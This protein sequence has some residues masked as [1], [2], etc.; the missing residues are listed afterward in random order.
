M[1]TRIDN[2]Q[3]VQAFLAR[4]TDYEKQLG[5]RTRD[6]FDL[7]RMAEMLNLLL[8]P[9]T[10]YES[11]H[12]AGTKGKGS[13]SAYLAAC[14]QSQGLVTGLFTSPHLE[15]LTQRIE[16]AGNEITEREMV[17]A[18]REVVAAVES[19]AGGAPDITFFELLT[20]TAMVA[21]RRAGVQIAV[22]EVGLGGRLDSTNVITPLVSVITEIGLDHMQQLGDTIR[23]IAAEKA[24]IIKPGIP[25]VCGAQD[26]E[27]QRVIRQTARDL[28]APVLEYGRE[29]SVRGVN[30][31]NGHI[32]FT[33]D[34]A[35]QRY[36]KVRLAHPA[37]YMVD[38]A[39]HALCALEVIARAV[40]DL[41]P[42]GAL[43][44][45][46]AMDALARVRLP[47]KF[48]ILP[49][50]PVIVVDSSHNELS[51]KAA[52]ATARAVARGPVVC[53]VGLAKDKD[54]EACMRR[55]AEGADAA[56]F[57]TYYSPRQNRPED[58]LR[59]YSKFGGRQGSMEEHP[60][61]ALESAVEQAGQDGLVLI[62]GSTY[63]AG[64]LRQAALEYNGRERET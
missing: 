30:R 43:H 21:F 13:T 61:A 4:H 7:E 40:P 5:G 28:E 51:L 32:E 36:E 35:G 27:A 50:R 6:T 59:T 31:V 3:D 42:D 34:I 52:L 10:A 53:V 1:A 37:R 49:G 58:L 44:R 14:L 12:V 17:E 26:P 11:A 38:N 15:R 39:A 41:L 64:A 29:Y 33:A 25:V 24:G 47:G 2:L 23:E 46:L 22:F 60:E 56:V 55:V 8:R 9:D 57:T 16:I 20:L 19:Q 62:T 54:L 63:L 48:E 45:D 18:F